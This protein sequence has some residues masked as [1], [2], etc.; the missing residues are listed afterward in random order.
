[1]LIYTDKATGERLMA[2]T[3]ESLVDLLNKQSRFPEADNRAFM[4]AYAR[5]AVLDSDTDIRATDE[6]SFIEDLVKAG[7]LVS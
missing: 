5:R 7:H 3:P 6:A 2:K 1:M 4:L